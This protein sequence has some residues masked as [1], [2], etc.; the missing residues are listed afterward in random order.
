[1]GEPK[2]SVFDLVACLGGNGQACGFI[3]DDYR[4]GRR[5]VPED[6]DM[7]RALYGYGCAF[8]DEGACHNHRR[9]GGG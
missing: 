4:K 2:K 5:S 1:V 3:A 6:R 9:L 8:G 7:A